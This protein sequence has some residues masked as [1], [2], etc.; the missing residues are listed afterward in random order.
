MIG[1]SV[2]LAVIVLALTI[3]LAASMLTQSRDLDRN[4]EVTS[5]IINVIGEWGKF[6]VPITHQWGLSDA[7]EN[8]I[9]YE[10][11]FEKKIYTSS[12]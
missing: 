5:D 3:T 1:L 6:R 8:D 2:F 7:Y 9:F 10:F 4:V 11:E 12:N